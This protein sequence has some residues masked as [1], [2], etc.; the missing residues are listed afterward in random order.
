MI[1][2]KLRKNSQKIILKNM[3]IEEAEKTIYDKICRHTNFRDIAKTEF[4]ISGVN[5]KFNISQISKI[6]EKFE[7]KTKSIN[8][9]PD[10]ATVFKLFRDG[11]DPIDVIIE[12]GLSYEYVKQ[13]YEEFLEFE[14]KEVVPKRIMNSLRELGSKLWKIKDYGDIRDAMIVG[15]ESRLLLINEYVIP[16][17]YCEIPM[18]IDGEMLEKTKKHLISQQ[19]HHVQCK[20]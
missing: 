15:V 18:S 13:S 16:C 2:K 12:T 17:C 8:L 5:K 10:K 4:Q 14:Q 11:L 7:P 9:D 20:P 1:T 19:W 6:K 3:T